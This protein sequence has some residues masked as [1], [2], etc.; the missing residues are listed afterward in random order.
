MRLSEVKAGNTWKFRRMP[1]DRSASA[2]KVAWRASR[3]PPG[4]DPA[5]PVPSDWIFPSAVA[6]TSSARFP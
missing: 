1:L 6:V 2:P 5:R 3:V 4:V